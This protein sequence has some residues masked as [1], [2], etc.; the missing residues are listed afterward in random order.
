MF[1]LIVSIIVYM[2]SNITKCQNPCGIQVEWQWNGS[3]GT[4]TIVP[5][6]FQGVI[7]HGMVESMWNP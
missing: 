4:Y 2:Y 3:S 6:G 1:Y 7:P 5:G